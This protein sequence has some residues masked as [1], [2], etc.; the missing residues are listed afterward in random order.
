[1]LQ[2]VLSKLNSKRIILA[3]GSPR[4]KGL[5]EQIVCVKSG[6]T[7]YTSIS[8]HKHNEK[9]AV[10]GNLILLHMGWFWEKN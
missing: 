8:F 7:Q 5:L 3:S 1:M 6:K 9:N 4:R 10:F 2:P